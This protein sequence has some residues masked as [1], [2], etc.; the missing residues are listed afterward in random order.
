[1][2]RNDS[3]DEKRRTRGPCLVNKTDMDRATVY[4]HA[5]GFKVTGFKFSRGEIG[6]TVEDANGAVR[7]I[8]LSRYDETEALRKAIENDNGDD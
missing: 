3:G 8:D 5:L 2:G 1:M 6:I 4:A 7:E